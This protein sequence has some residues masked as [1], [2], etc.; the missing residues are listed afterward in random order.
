M[1]RNSSRA[2]ARLTVFRSSRMSGVVH[3]DRSVH[4]NPLPSR[5]RRGGK[6]RCHQ[7][8]GRNV[9][10]FFFGNRSPLKI[11]FPPRASILS[12]TPDFCPATPPLR[13][14]RYLDYLPPAMVI[15]RAVRPSYQ[16]RPTSQATLPIVRCKQS[17]G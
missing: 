15:L 8:Q 6:F 11:G 12:L 14:G 10:P 9:E 3:A 5:G 2:D 4:S 1:S 13:A 16:R 17:F 7:C